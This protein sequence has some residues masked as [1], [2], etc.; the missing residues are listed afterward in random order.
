MGY[1]SF[2]VETGGTLNSGGF[3]KL[4]VGG[5]LKIRLNDAPRA[6]FVFEPVLGLDARREEGWGV[7]PYSK[8]KFEI[9]L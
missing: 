5:G 8:L 7:T 1:N 3:Q 6:R 4:T 2:F 9:T